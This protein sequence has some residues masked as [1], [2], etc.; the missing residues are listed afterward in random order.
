VSDFIRDESL[1]GPCLLC[2]F[3]AAN[4][5]GEGLGACEEYEGPKRIVRE[6]SAEECLPDLI[7]PMLGIAD[8]DPA[9]IERQRKVA[10][11][12]RRH[13]LELEELELEND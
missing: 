4:H 2:G 3:S 13:R 12:K 1:G 6:F 9:D 10:V 5:P 8:P 11:M 7:G